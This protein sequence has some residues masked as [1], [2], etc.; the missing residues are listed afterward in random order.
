MYDACTDHVWSGCSSGRRGGGAGVGFVVRHYAGPVHYSPESLLRKNKDQVPGELVTL[1]AQ[2]D[3][4]FV[5]ALTDLIN[6]ANKEK[7]GSLVS[8]S[9]P[10][11]AATQTTPLR[12]KVTLLPLACTF[13]PLRCLVNI[14]LLFPT[15]YR[16]Y[17]HN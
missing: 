6:P 14:I 15:N 10:A 2:S 8:R 13:C 4:S 3:L 7:Y 9:P 17:P 16:T 12:D 5:A 1:L 11:A